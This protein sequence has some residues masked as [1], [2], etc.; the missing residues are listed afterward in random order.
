MKKI[1]VISVCALVIV[2]ALFVGFVYRIPTPTKVLYKNDYT[3]NLSEA[4]RHP[5]SII[6]SKNKKP[7]T[8]W[9]N[10][11]KNAGS[12]MVGLASFF[13]MLSNITGY[14]VK[15]IIKMARRKKHGHG[16]TG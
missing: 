5:E 7:E 9:K 14:N 4:R 3:F 13:V 8:D 15:D 6:L 12:F 1:I 10:I 2:S 16:A 11:F